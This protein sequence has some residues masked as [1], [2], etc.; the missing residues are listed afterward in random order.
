MISLGLSL[1]ALATRPRPLPNPNA[2]YAVNGVVPRLVWDFEHAYLSASPLPL[3]RSGVASY[4]AQDGRLQS[5]SADVPRYDWGTG[6]RALLMESAGTNLCN[7][8]SAPQI[9]ANVYATG[10]ATLSVVDA[11][12]ALAVPGLDAITAGKAY[13]VDNSANTTYVFCNITGTPSTTGSYVASAYARLFSGPGGQST[14]RIDGAAAQQSAYITGSSFQLYQTAASTPANSQ[15]MLIRVEAGCVVDFVLPWYRA[16]AETGGY[17]PSFGLASNRGADV[18]TVSMAS[19]GLP[20]TQQMK[21]VSATGTTT[22]S[23]VAGS[24]SLGTGRH[25]LLQDSY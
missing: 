17:V 13:R 15:R 6:R 12:A 22:P 20:A 18:L 7:A 19:Y 2:A 8:Y 1:P 9:D 5:A 24:L 23:A 3:S 25:Y 14:V 11:T 10:S 21:L 16:A 4:I